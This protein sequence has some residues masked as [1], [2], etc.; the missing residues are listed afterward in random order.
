MP[1]MTPAADPRA[2]AAV[3]KAI[4]KGE[5]RRPEVCEVCGEKPKGR[6][7]IHA[8]HKDYAKPLDVEW[9][10]PRCH[11][12]VGPG[13]N[14]RTDLG[15][16]MFRITLADDQWT[17]LRIHAAMEMTSLTAAVSQ[18]LSEDAEQIHENFPANLKRPY[19]KR[20]PIVPEKART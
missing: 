15:W 12:Q 14:G 2:H 16:R 10:C 13:E 3:Q 4:A 20:E 18:M 17:V 6:A 8:H 11:R 9:L 1:E 7:K 5:L 19:L